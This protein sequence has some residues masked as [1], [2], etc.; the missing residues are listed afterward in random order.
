ME[1]TFK[2]DDYINLHVI[3]VNIYI[4]TLKFYIYTLKLCIYTLRYHTNIYSYYYFYSFININIYNHIC[5]W[6]NYICI[7]SRQFTTFHLAC[8]K[9]HVPSKLTIEKSTQLTALPWFKMVGFRR[10]KPPEKNEKTH[11]K[12]MEIYGVSHSFFLVPNDLK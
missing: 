4:H 9:L 1:H 2:L 12:Y 5:I 11:I 7:H 6:L 10:D 3:N 8:F